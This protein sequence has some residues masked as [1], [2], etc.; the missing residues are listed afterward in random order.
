M[1]ETSREASRRNPTIQTSRVSDSE[2]NI[3]GGEENDNNSFE[4]FRDVT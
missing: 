2:K 1:R 3:N 4:A